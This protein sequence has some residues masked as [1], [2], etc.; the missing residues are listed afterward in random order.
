MSPQNPVA[1]AAGAGVGK[2][3]ISRSQ[4]DSIVGPDLSLELIQIDSIDE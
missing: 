4:K 3:G 2:S 1:A